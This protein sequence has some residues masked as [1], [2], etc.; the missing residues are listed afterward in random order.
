MVKESKLY[1]T[2][3]A[4]RLEG[5]DMFFFRGFDGVNEK[6][7]FKLETIASKHKPT[8]K[9]YSNLKGY[10]TIEG[11]EIKAYNVRKFRRA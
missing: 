3:L 7:K 8:K 5:T 1:K 11:E 9:E 2:E 6:N 10:L 4:K